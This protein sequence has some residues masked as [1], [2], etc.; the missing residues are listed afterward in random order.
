VVALFAVLSIQ[1][2]RLQ[3]IEGS[4]YRSQAATNT[5]RTQALVPVRG[6]IYDRNGLPLVK[7]IPAYSAAIVPAD[8]PEDRQEAVLPQVGRILNV[9]VGEMKLVIE[10]GRESK[11]PFEPVI[12]KSDLDEETALIVKEMTDY[13]PGLQLITE[14]RREYLNAEHFAH[15]LGYTGPI[16]EEEYE[17]LQDDGYGMNDRLGKAGVEAVYERYLRGRPGERQTEN[18]ADGRVVG[19]VGETP[20]IPGSSLVLS[21]DS[22]LQTKVAEIL[23]GAMDATGSSSAVAALMDPRNGDMLA[24]VSLPEYNNN[25]F[26]TKPSAKDVEALLNDPRKPLLDHAIS[27]MFPPGSI[28]KQ[29]T[30]LAGLQEGVITPHTTYVSD[31]VLRVQS[32]YDPNEYFTFPDWTPGIGPVD[33]YHAIA[34]SSDIYFY[35]VAGGHF[36]TGIVGLGADRLANYD[37]AFGLGSPTGIDLFGES[38]GLVPDSQWKQQVV[39]EPW[40][41]GDSYHFGIGQGYVAVTPLQMLVAT[42]AVANRGYVLRP[43]VVKQILDER[44][45]VQVTFD[46]DVKHELP[47]DK[48]YLEDLVTGMTTATTWS[49]GTAVPAAISGVNVAGKTGTAEHGASFC[50]E[51][52][53]CSTH[54]WFAGFAPA[55][56]PEVAIIVFVQNGGGHADAAPVAHDILDYFFH[57][58]PGRDEGSE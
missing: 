15:I 22:E 21:I 29:I 19:L 13:I 44:G 28:F 17:E 36:D 38:A 52:V 34:I 3:L 46:R 23:Q 33:F 20:A 7:N 47:I 12:L 35:Y 11:D 14:P 51:G 39:G 53:T 40:V 30:G 6:L 50:R 54:G 48:Q 24:L 56:D 42:S 25:I 57:R 26:S 2:L 31:G 58:W 32:Q 9:R 8:L 37:R 4:D 41:L 45:E 43:H 5:L 18:D 49:L 10:K 16:D 1:L 27:E 55:D